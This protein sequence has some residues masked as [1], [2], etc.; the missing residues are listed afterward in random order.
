MSGMAG[1]GKTDDAFGVDRR[2]IVQVDGRRFEFD[3]IERETAT[4]WVCASGRWFDKETLRG[5]RSKSD[6]VSAAWLLPADDP[7]ALRSIYFD[8]ITSAAHQIQQSLRNAQ[9]HNFD[10]AD[11]RKAVAELTAALDRFERLESGR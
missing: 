1:T 3:T 9:A 11:T 10:P 6:F 4:R 2:V 8:R 5:P 7:S